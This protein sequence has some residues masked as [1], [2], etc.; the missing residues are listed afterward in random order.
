MSR[1]TARGTA[2]DRGKRMRS[3]SLA[4]WALP[5]AVLLAAC[6][7]LGTNPGGMAARI[8]GLEFDLYQRVHPRLYQDTGIKSG[9]SVKVL[10]ADAASITRFGQW[11]WSGSVLARLIDE[12]KAQGASIVVLDM[13]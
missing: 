4:N 12:L 13:P 7:M 11:P 6:L 5:L 2:P 3:G 9:H 1:R 10:D 8:G